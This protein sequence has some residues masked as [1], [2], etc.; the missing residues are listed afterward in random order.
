MSGS[1]IVAVVGSTGYVGKMLMPAFLEGLK[2]GKLKEVRV[3]TAEAKL[4]SQQVQSY[5]AS[6]AKAFTVDYSDISTVTAALKGVDAVVSTLGSGEGIEKV[7]T[8]LLDALVATK[9]KLYF[10][11][12]FGTNH[13]KYPNYDHPAFEG[14]RKHFLKAKELG[15]N[16]IRMLTGC[17]MEFTFGK[18]FGFDCISGVWTVVGNA[19]DI[20]CAITAER[21]LGRFTLE[22][23]LLAHSDI[24]KCP[25]ALEVYS[26]MKTLREYAKALDKVSERDTKIVQV[27][28]DEFKTQYEGTQDFLKL[29]MVL[30]AEGAFDYSKATGNRLLNP[31]ESLWKLKRFEE[32]A[33]ETGGTP[34]SFK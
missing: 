21:D 20:P 15:L 5:V 16:P 28:F 4:N 3:L 19:A 18:W 24:T 7:K 25:D 13:Y 10:P 31:N 29:I 2:D 9:V 32:F 27:Q 14:K 17:I 26:D 8:T 22:A 34:R 30:F 6:G 1:P 33:K 12:E 23:V 11:S